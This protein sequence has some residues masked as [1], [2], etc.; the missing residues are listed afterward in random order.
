MLANLDAAP[1]F[2][3]TV[4]PTSTIIPF[5]CSSSKGDLLNREFVTARHC[6]SLV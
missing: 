5:T 2:A 4:V 6:I 3:L 1:V